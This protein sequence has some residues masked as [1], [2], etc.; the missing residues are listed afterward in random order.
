MQN[1]HGEAFNTAITK[2]EVDSTNPYFKSVDGILYN[3]SGTTLVKYAGAYSNTNTEF[4]VLYS[5][6]AQI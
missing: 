2:I 4:T 3:K 6:L 1:I 5:Q